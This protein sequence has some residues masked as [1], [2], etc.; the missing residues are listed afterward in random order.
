MGFGRRTNNS[1]AQGGQQMGTR[2]EERSRP[3]AQRKQRLSCTTL[4]NPADIQDHPAEPPPPHAVTMI[5]LSH[6]TEEERERILAVL[7]R[8]EELKKVDK[9]RVRHLEQQR[10]QEEL[11]R[12]TG[13]WFYEAQWQ[14]HG[15]RSHGADI[16]KASL[17]ESSQFQSPSFSFEGNQ[18]R[19]EPSGSPPA[20]CTERQMI[21]I[22]LDPLQEQPPRTIPS[23]AKKRHNPFNGTSP[24]LETP[25]GG[26]A[27]EG[28]PPASSHPKPELL[29]P[30][31]TDA[32]PGAPGGVGGA[33]EDQTPMPKKRTIIYTAQA[34]LPDCNGVFP[35][36]LDGA[37]W[38]DSSVPRYTSSP[39]QQLRPLVG[40]GGGAREKE[41]AG[42]REDATLVTLNKIQVRVSSSVAPPK[43]AR[44]LEHTDKQEPQEPDL[45]ALETSALRDEA[46]QGGQGA[47]RGPGPSS[48]SGGKQGTGGSELKPLEGCPLFAPQHMGTTHTWAAPDAV[49]KGDPVER[50]VAAATF[51]SPA[52]QNQ[53]LREEGESI[54]KVLEWFSKSSDSSED[55]SR[56]ACENVDDDSEKA[57]PPEGEGAASAEMEGVVI[58][59]P[60][61]SDVD[62]DVAPGGAP[63]GAKIPGGKDRFELTPFRKERTAAHQ[64]FWFFLNT[65]KSYQPQRRIAAAEIKLRPQKENGG[66]LVKKSVP[67][68]DDS[69]SPVPEAPGQVQ[70][71][72]GEDERP[73]QSVEM[74]K[75]FWEKANSG[76]NANSKNEAKR[77]LTSQAAEAENNKAPDVHEAGKVTSWLPGTSLSPEGTSSAQETLIF[78]SAPAVCESEERSVEEGVTS[79]QAAE[80]S[81]LSLNALDANSS[82]IS[83]PDVVSASPPREK[84][85]TSCENR[86]WLDWLKE[87]EMKDANKSV[88][89][90]EVHTISPPGDASQ[91]GETKEEDL[92]VTFSSSRNA[93]PVQQ[94][95][96]VPLVKQGHGQTE[97]KAGKIGSLKSFWEKESFAPQIVST[98]KEETK[99]NKPTTEPALDNSVDSSSVELGDVGMEPRDPTTP[100]Y[101]SPLRHR[102]KFTVLSMRER[103]EKLQGSSADNSQFRNIREF[104]GGA[105]SNA[106]DPEAPTSE[107]QLAA[108]QSPSFKGLESTDV[109][110]QRQE[111]SVPFINPNY[112]SQIPPSD[113][114]K[115][116]IRQF[117]DEKSSTDIQ[118][119]TKDIGE[120]KPPLSPLQLS[121]EQGSPVVG[122]ETNPEA[123]TLL[124]S[125][126]TSG[127]TSAGTGADSLSLSNSEEQAGRRRSGN[128]NEKIKGLQGASMSV[129]EE[130]HQEPPGSGKK[131]HDGNQSGENMSGPSREVQQ[132]LVTSTISHNYLEIVAQKEDQNA[133][134][135]EKKEEQLKS[136]LDMS[137]MRVSVQDDSTL[138][139]KTL[140]TSKG[141]KIQDAR[142]SDGKSGVSVSDTPSQSQT[143][144]PWGSED[145]SPVMMALRRAAARPVQSYKSLEDITSPSA[146][147]AGSAGRSSPQV[148]SW[149]LDQGS[150]GCSLRSRPRCLSR[151]LESSVP[152]GSFENPEQVKKMSKSV[153]SFLQKQGNESDGDSSSETSF[154][155]SSWRTGS[156]LTNLS[157]SS[158]LM[159]ASSVG[160]SVASLYGEDFGSVDVKGTIQF[161]INYVQKLKEFHIF[162][163]QC[164][165]LAVADPRKNRTD[166]YVKSYLLPDKAKMGKRKTSVKKKTQD[167]IFNEIL[168]YR[169]TAATLRAQTLNLSVWHNDTFGR[170]SFL[171]EVDVDLSS[172][173]F[174]NTQI[175]DF[176]LKS[177]VTSRLL[178]SDYR[179]E[180]RLAV[181]FLPQLSDTVRTATTGEVHVWVKDC[182][183]L[184]VIRGVA[185]DPYV[186]CFVL[187]DTSRK[188]CQKT[189]VLK[190]T[191]SP[192][193]NH[194]MVY[195][196]FQAEDLREACVELTVWDRDRLATH[197]LGGLR[198]SLGTGT[199]YGEAVDWMDSNRE[200]TALWEKMMASPSEWVEGSLSLRMLTR[201][202]KVR[203]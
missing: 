18:S 12:L 80:Q 43:P 116:C 85:P 66:H 44:L 148:K 97:N 126:G 10:E 15:D 190:R 104:W 156:S 78:P 47:D 86:S 194:T 157:H 76:S 99:Q 131:S 21:T 147:K 40:S 186:K 193:F 33:D 90:E 165:D 16:I 103:M 168:R 39:M 137:T 4:L 195:D 106:P 167:P 115:F 134:E 28:D 191:S 180:M 123:N 164:R 200:E 59:G 82:S 152:T 196:G 187:P 174:R 60:A 150:R 102:P 88:S 52:A 8:D 121:K 84:T 96:P 108:L 11:R 122:L 153:P 46:E 57:G 117:R 6:L 138:R 158:S 72:E 111:A 3:E 31:E 34:F 77:K 107:N 67:E 199:S 169:V 129:G 35:V 105:A 100:T 198:L 64:P 144:S 24:R 61:S 124:Q 161:S 95:T 91:A 56:K 13:R 63:D 29:T 142:W 159:S 162:V 182:K 42:P 17:L 188:S 83:A 120:K 45:L 203:K 32:D 93:T 185:V 175:T 146:G 14:R 26:R 202:K 163:V 75:S 81:S 9:K 27:G 48:T 2:A 149:C 65:E 155:S 112:Y 22:H 140:Q 125:H 173:D 49:N 68:T 184:P 30:R 53:E 89:S 189:R 1:S 178:P 176:P 109:L 160:G 119:L 50:D 7:D 172:W 38:S 128:I 183:N 130:K 71:N 92:L 19:V 58:E 70:E 73:S 166:P 41:P 5:D 139:W 37:G 201:A 62:V 36:L 141:Q 127:P 135:S 171:G 170:N 55:A 79:Q 151:P 197:F 101:S 118:P 54:A 98:P 94:P 177:R 114:R 20:R 181:R 192:V 143:S 145:H 25:G 51:T 23:P 113:T 154:S 136:E 87:L 132:L 69:A 110:Q 74:L 133:P 179:G